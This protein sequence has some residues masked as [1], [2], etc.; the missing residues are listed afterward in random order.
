MPLPRA[1]RAVD[2]GG[3]RAQLSRGCAREL[4]GRRAAVRGRQGRRLRPRRGRRPRAPRW[5]A[6]R[7][8]WPSPR[9]R[10]RAALRAAGIERRRPRAWAR[11]PETSWPSRST[12]APTSSPGARAFVA[13]AAAPGPRACTSSS[14]PGWAGSA[15]ATR[16]RRRRVAEAV[17]GARARARGPDDALRHR[18]RA[19][20]RVLRRAAR[21]L[22]RL[23]GAAARAR[24]PA[25]SC[26]PPTA[27]RRCASP[28]AHFDL[29]RCGVALYGLDPFGEDPA[30][31]D[32][33]PA[34]E[35]RSYVA[36]VK[37]CAP[38][39]SAGYGRRFVADRRHVARDDADRLRRR[40]CGA[41]LTNNAEVLIGGRRCPLVGTVCMDNITVDLGPDGGG[42]RRRRRGRADRR[43][44]RERIIAEEV[45]AP[46]GHD[47]LRGH[48]R[49]HARV[50]RVH[51]RGGELAR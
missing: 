25:A 12:P 1:W 45:A 20:R 26:T 42:V 7:T 27:R 28:R 5:P 19:R 24:I 3:D 33:E 48:L 18:R 40:L 23:G 47:Q 22:R 14:T 15:R 34:L 46:A 39:E 10:R 11:S 29:V 35:L 51:H 6:A 37:P 43:A 17:A 16:A 38:G 50:P 41:A 44:R 4:G 13:R 49:A 2:L 36:A 21:A 30:A 8:G 9:P 32:L 31:R